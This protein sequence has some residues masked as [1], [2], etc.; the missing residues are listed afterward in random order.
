[1]DPQ[2]QFCHNPDCPARGA[3]GQGNIQ[4][5]SRAERRYKCTTGGRTF[6]EA[7]GTPYYR[8]RTAD[9]VIDT[10]LTLLTHGCPPQAIVAAFGL[11][12]R[13]VAAWQRQAGQHCRRVHAHV[14][15]QGRVDLGHVQADEMWVKMV[16]RRIGMAM[17]MAVPS[18][19]WLGGVLS[20]RRDTAL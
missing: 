11:D 5:H 6:A 19:L 8:K 4:I 20:P 9:D 7:R 1:M 13:T 10:V 3:V 2:D 17:A 14:V 16:G 18:R 12:E 15:Q